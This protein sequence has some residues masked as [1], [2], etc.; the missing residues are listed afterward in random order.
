[1]PPRCRHLSANPSDHHR[2]HAMRIA[3]IIDPIARTPHIPNGIGVEIHIAVSSA[4]RSTNG[5]AS[6]IPPRMK[7][8]PGR[9]EAIR[10]T[11]NGNL[12]IAA[13]AAVAAAGRRRCASSRIS[14]AG[15]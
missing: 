14:L 12:T 1:V 8:P 15:R 3:P 11:T 7:T 4:A 6:S 2:H 10:N 5:S 13:L 9:T